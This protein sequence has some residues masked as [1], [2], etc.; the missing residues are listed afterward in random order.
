VEIETEV[1]SL[2]LKVLIKDAWALYQRHILK[3]L[4]FMV[5]V[6][7]LEMISNLHIALN[8]AYQLILAPILSAGLF[9]ALKHSR[10]EKTGYSFSVFFGGIKR[11]FD[12]IFLTI[13]LNVR[14]F[15][16]FILLVIPFI[17]IFNLYT[18]CFFMVLDYQCDVYES[19]ERSAHLVRPFFMKILGFNVIAG[20]WTIPSFFMEF[21]MITSAPYIVLL[22][23]LGVP[24]SACLYFALYERLVGVNTEKM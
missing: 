18:L 6:T 24:F 9:F 13:V 19:L 15:I 5:I 17:Y 4:P 12:V 7:L 8:V 20:I 11:A 14:F 10:V 3:F 21:G 22:S 1:E 2:H 23:V 16:A